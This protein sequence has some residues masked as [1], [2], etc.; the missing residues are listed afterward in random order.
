MRARG[1]HGGGCQNRRRIAMRRFIVSL[2]LALV[3]LLGLIASALTTRAQ[4]ATPDVAAS[5][6]IAVEQTTFGYLEVVPSTP[7]SIEYFRLTM[8]PGTKISGPRGDPGVGAHIVESGT[9]T[10]TFDEDMPLTQNGQRHGVV[11]AGEEAQLGPGEGFLWLP[12]AAG[13]FRNDSA[14]PAVVLVV[15]LYPQAGTPVAG[16]A[17]TPAP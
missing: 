8:P 7:L 4:E 16:M 10:V 11:R 14:E 5:D 13:E 9:L 2:S 1:F 15:L 12:P 6:E 3:V 17:A